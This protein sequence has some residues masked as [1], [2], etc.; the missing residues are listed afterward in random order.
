MKT[1]SDIADRSIRKAVFVPSCPAWARSELRE[2]VIATES[3]EPRLF[4][5]SG[6]TDLRAKEILALGCR[7]EMNQAW[8]TLEKIRAKYPFQ[9]PTFGMEFNLLSKSLMDSLNAS[10]KTRRIK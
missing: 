10:E 2:L 7:S 8:K 3:I 5:H 4:F 9:S 6:R 1:I